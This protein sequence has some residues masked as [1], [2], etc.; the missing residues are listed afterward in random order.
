MAVT[1][2]S[3]CEKDQSRTKVQIVFDASA[4]YNNVA[5]NDVIYQGPKFTELFAC[6]ASVYKVSHYSTA[7]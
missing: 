5:L 4:K 3:H 2:L 7:D 1:S 6:F